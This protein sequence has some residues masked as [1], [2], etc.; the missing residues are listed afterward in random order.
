MVMISILEAIL[1]P[2]DSV[3][4]VRMV[5][6]ILVVAIFTTTLAISTPSSRRLLSCS[7]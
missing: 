1:S 3:C 7:S 5:V 6:V 4:L 2:D